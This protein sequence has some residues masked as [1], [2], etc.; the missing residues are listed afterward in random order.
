MKTLQQDWLT[1]GI[2]DFEYKKYVLLGYLKNVQAC[3]DSKKL[4]PYL[5]DLVFHYRNLC[6]IKE[7]K[8]LLYEHFPRKITKADFNKLKLHYQNLVNDD[9]AMQ[10]LSQI[11]AYAIPTLKTTLNE[12]KELYE[13][14]EEHCVL[15][16]IGICPL[17]VNDG[18]MLLH[19]Q[20]RS[21]TQVYQYQVTVFE[22]AD[23]SYRGIHT[24]YL[25]TF[26]K[27]IGQTFEYLKLQLIKKYKELPNPS[28]YLIDIRIDIPFHET[29]MPVAKR[30]L[31]KY[32]NQAA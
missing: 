4:Y 7:N 23:E 26:K 8:E 19:Q 25:E 6:S 11:L 24:Q 9:Q 21:I 30:M 14:V 1:Q 2:M 22:H 32:L 17:Y 29:A 18:Y 27:S 16:P 28:T 31:V 3:F 13:L 15:E 10:E 12:G 5:S 20:S